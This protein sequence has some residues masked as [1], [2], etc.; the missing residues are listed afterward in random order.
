VYR[1]KQLTLLVSD[2]L[3]GLAPSSGS[4]QKNDV[5]VVEL[6]KQG[7][8]SAS[9]FS[10]YLGNILKRQPS[11]IW[12]GGYDGD[13]IRTLPGYVNMTDQQIDAYITYLPLSNANYWAVRLDTVSLDA[14]FPVEIQARHVIFDTGTSMSYI[15]LKDYQNL[16]SGITRDKECVTVSKYIVKANQI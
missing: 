6:H 5:F 4:G 2:G 9:V 14:R 3:L 10:M 15:P 7:L 16:V 1:A 12:F 13:F 8:I 11:K